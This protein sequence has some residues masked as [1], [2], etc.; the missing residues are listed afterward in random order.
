MARTRPTG[1]S[2][3]TTASGA[4]RTR[5]LTSNLP[6][7]APQASSEAAVLSL[8]ARWKRGITP[9]LHEC[10]PAGGSHGKP[11][12]TTKILS[13]AR[14]RGRVAARGARTASGDA[15]GR[16]SQ[17]RVGRVICAIRGGVPPGPERDRLYRGQECS[18]RRPLGRRA[19]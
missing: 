3:L 9:P 11:R 18:G 15:G 10:P 2:A 13:L 19:V 17:Q 6:G 7:F 14:R 5:L 8:T 16:V 12:R 1:M 4:K